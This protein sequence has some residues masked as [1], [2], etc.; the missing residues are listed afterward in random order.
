MYYRE[1]DAQL[2]IPLEGIFVMVHKDYCLY[3]VK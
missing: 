2:A 1:V 3:I